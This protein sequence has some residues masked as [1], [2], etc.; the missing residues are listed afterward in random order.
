MAHADGIYVNGIG[1]RAMSLGG[2]DVA[3]ASDALGAMGSNPAGLAF[4]TGP[5][6]NLGFVGGLAQG[7]FS[8]P[9]VSSGNLHGNIEGLPE[10]AFA[11]PFGKW[12]FG[13]SCAPLAALDADWS[14]FDPPGG[15]GGKTTYG[16]QK[17]ESEIVLIRSAL[18]VA[19]AFTP[20]FSFGASFGA[21]YNQNQL[22]APYIFQTQPTVKGAKTLLNLRTDGFGY[23]GQAGFLFRPIPQLELGLTYM[24]PV[25]VDS[26]GDA[27]G[28]VGAQFGAASIPFHYDA[29]VRNNFPQMVSAGASWK[30]H[31]QW[32][33]IAQV[34]W[35]NWSDAFKSLQVNLSNG[36]NATVNSVIGSSALQ[37]NV[38]LHWH[39]EFVYRAGL[40][41]E[42]ITNL[43]LRAGYSFGGDPVS[44]Q[45]L[46]PLTAAIMENTVTAGVGYHW[47]NLQ[48]DLAYQYDVPVTRN[49]GTSGL[50]SGEYSNSSVD[51][52]LHWLA[53]TIGATF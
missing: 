4:L 19:Y 14:Y 13:I 15:L 39:N 33:A 27:N 49:V 44:G 11:I 17:Q 20:N 53:L 30:F 52:N 8:K 34:D 3:Q 2:A 40:E 18:G 21:D 47:R 35:I 6:A 24:A 12:S 7:T 45:T 29:E 1:A 38:P 9:G 16:P 23:D 26:Y 42:V 36:N 51:V 31:P 22:Q 43:F 50:L 46:T 10:A 5:N 41:Y 48:F 32:R 28:D 37:D 25:H